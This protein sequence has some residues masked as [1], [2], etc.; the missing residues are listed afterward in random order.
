MVM[1]DPISDMLTRLRNAIGADHKEVLMPSSG[2]KVAVAKILKDEGYIDGF[3]VAEK[4]RNPA[5]RALR[6]LRH[7]VREHYLNRYAHTMW[8]VFA[9][10]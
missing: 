2:F 7:P 5:V 1:T 8:A 3:K 9:P 4:P 10:R 6:R